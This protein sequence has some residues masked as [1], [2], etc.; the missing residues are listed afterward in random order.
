MKNRH[1]TCSVWGGSSP[2]Y[3]SACVL[4]SS[5]Y[6]IV[7]LQYMHTCT[8]PN[9]EDG[10]NMYPALKNAPVLFAYQHLSVCGDLTISPSQIFSP[11]YPSS[12]SCEECIYQTLTFG[13]NIPY[14]FILSPMSQGEHSQCYTLC[15][16][17]TLYNVENQLENVREQQ[18][19]FEP[20]AEAIGFFPFKL[21]SGLVFLPFL[22]N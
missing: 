15:P 12:L 10:L 13:V 11:V 8:T 17:S 16:N 21:V 4:G 6:H 7:V 22:N 1:S 14:L 20:K 9:H 18:C 5:Q 19:Q 2:F 3:F